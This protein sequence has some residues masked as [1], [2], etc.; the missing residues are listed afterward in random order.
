MI[1]AFLRPRPRT[2]VARILRAYRKSIRSIGL[3]SFNSPKPAAT[4]SASWK[5]RRFTARALAPPWQR[6]SPISGSGD[7]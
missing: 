2:H 1:L 4:S 6:L 5:I 7:V 3:S